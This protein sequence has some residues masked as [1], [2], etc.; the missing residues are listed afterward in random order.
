MSLTVI[1]NESY[2][3]FA[4]QL[5]AEYEEDYGIGFGKVEVTAFAKLADPTAEQYLPLGQET[6][7][8]NLIQKTHILYYSYRKSGRICGHRLWMS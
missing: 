7:K 8:M 1:A 2:E 5:Q 4:R 3:D 6:S